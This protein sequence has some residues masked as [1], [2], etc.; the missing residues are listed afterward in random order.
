MAAGVAAALLLPN[1]L[2]WRSGNPYLDTAR[3]VTNYQEGSGHG[4]LVQYERSLL[5]ALRHPLLGVGPGNWPVV[6]PQHVPANDPSLD[7]NEGGMTANPWPSSDWMAFLTERGLAAATLLALA[8]V[9][10]ARDAL[11]RLRVAV[12]AE[13]AL[14]AAALLGTVTA[15]CI[16]GLFDAVLLL[17]LPSL[18][19]WSALGALTATQQL[20][21]PSPRT[22]RFGM[23]LLVVAFAATL[24]SAAQLIAMDVYETRSDRALLEQAS[25]LDPGNYR[26]HLRLAR[27]GKRTLRCEHA[28]AAHALFPAAAA[29]REVL[30]GCS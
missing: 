30:R 10:I 27:G 14:L 24:R 3:S 11:R 20:P 16:T 8:F 21:E 2:R 18:I 5:L 28:R 26:L 29:G 7:T 15:A 17:A 1:A 12:D 6:Y 22:L 23:P 13:E 4:R 19:V 25:H 9:R